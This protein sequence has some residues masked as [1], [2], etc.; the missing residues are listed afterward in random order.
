MQ[1]ISVIWLSLLA[2]DY[3]AAHVSNSRDRLLSIARGLP[4]SAQYLAQAVL[5]ILARLVAHHALIDDAEAEL[6]TIG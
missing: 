1:W 3:N 4:R 5:E 6:M 2:L